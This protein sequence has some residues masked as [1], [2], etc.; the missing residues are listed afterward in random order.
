MLRSKSTPA[1][2]APSSSL[3][4]SQSS[5]DIDSLRRKAA[6]RDPRALTALPT[7]SYTPVHTPR[8]EREDPFNLGSFFSATVKEDGDWA[9]LREEESEA[10]PTVPNRSIFSGIAEEDVAEEEVSRAK[11]STVIQQED[12]MGVLSLRQ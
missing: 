12:K 9:W 8:V 2:T 3:T 4:K 6:R 10:S 7:P 11:V 1:F 5:V